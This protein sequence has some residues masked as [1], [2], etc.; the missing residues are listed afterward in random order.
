[1]RGF[2][3]LRGQTRN[4]NKWK[5]FATATINY[6]KFVMFLES[7][8]KVKKMFWVLFKTVWFTC[9]VVLFLP[10]GF[11]GTIFFWYFSLKGNGNDIT[12]LKKKMLLLF[13]RFLIYSTIT[14]EKAFLLRLH[15]EYGDWKICSKKSQMLYFNYH[16]SSG[17]GYARYSSNKAWADQVAIALY[18]RVRKYGTVSNV[19]RTFTCG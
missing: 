17:K 7:N 4:E 11:L 3:L 1:M 16:K 19:W 15:N 9:L 10:F 2:W 13:M 8:Y 6:L 5:E 12:F 18:F 14:I